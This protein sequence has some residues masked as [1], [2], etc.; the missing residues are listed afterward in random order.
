MNGDEAFCQAMERLRRLR[1]RRN[2]SRCPGGRRKDGGDGPKAE[3]AEPPHAR[4]GGAGAG[5][6]APARSR[7]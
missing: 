3:A 2:R 7:C 5:Q 6:L 1:R 4:A